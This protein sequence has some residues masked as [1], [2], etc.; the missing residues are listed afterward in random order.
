MILSL[1]LIVIFFVI[2][3]IHF[4]WAFGGKWGLD[5]VLPT[6]GKGEKVLRPKKKETVFVGVGLLTFALFYVSLSGILTIGIPQWILKYGA[7]IIPFIF[8]LRAIGEFKYV[9]FFKRIKHTEFA[10][11]DKWFFTPLCLVIAL[12]G[13]II[14]TMN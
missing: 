9:G 8:I 14:Q 11:M 10:K 12:L 7:W 5:S 3:A 1:I 2:G 4:Y 6:N 13:I